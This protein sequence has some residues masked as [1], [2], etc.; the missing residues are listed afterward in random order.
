[1]C[2]AINSKKNGKTNLFGRTLDVLALC[3]EGVVIT[4]RDFRFKMRHEDDIL[5]HPAMIGAAIVKNG[6]PL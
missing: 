4:P 6:I 5:K 1:M 2:T 3:G